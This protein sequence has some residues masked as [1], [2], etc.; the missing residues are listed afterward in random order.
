[1][2]FAVDRN[3]P[4]L[5]LIETWL[6][7]ENNSITA[8]IKSYGY[9]II[10]KT[11]NCNKTGKMRGG[12][13]AIIFKKCLNLR[14]V[15]LSDIGSAETVSA[16]LKTSSGATLFCCC[17][18]R[19][20]HLSSIFFQEFDE[21]LSD[22]FL[23]FQNVIL[24]GDINIHLDD[25]YNSNA[26]KF[27]ELLS[28][29]GL[30]QIVDRPTHKSG[31]TLDIV[32]TTFKV[33]DTDTVVVEPAVT[34]L[35]PGCDHYPISFSLKKCF[36]MYSHNTKKDIIFRNIK[37]IDSKQFQTDLH[38]FTKL[39]HYPH[40]QLPLV[41]V[42]FCEAISSFNM[43]CTKLLDKHAPI[44]NKTI[45][46][47][48]ASPWFD[49]E[50]KDLR[51]LRRHAEKKW[52]NS[53][54]NEIRE[55]NRIRYMDLRERCNI[56]ALT[57][58]KQYFQEQFENL[59]YSPKSLFAFV[60]KFIDKEKILTLPPN[61]SLQQTAE[62]FNK[63]FQDKIDEIQ[64]N[65]KE[66]DL[67]KFSGDT[68][69]GKF[70]SEFHPTTIEEVTEVM[71]EC[72][73]KTS[74]ADSLPASLINDNINVLIPYF[75]YLVNLSLAT[76]NI[77]GI[78]L[79]HVTP[80]IK[81]HNSDTS[82]LKNYRPISNLS[83]IG[84]LVERIVLRRL[85]EHL[86]ANN[87][88][89]PNQSGYKQFHSTETLLIKIVDDLLIAFDER[90][91]TVVMLLDLSAAFDTVNHGKLLNILHFEIGITGMA[92]N[93]FR[94]FITGRSQRIKIGAA[95]SE[96]ITIKFGVPQGS[97][98][99]PVLFNLYIRSLYNT[100]KS[101]KFAIQGYADD[102]QIYQSFDAIHQYSLL[103][104]EISG[105]FNE[106]RQWMAAHFLQLNPDKTEIIV[107]GTPKVLSELSIHGTYLNDN[108]CVR[109]SPIV[110]NLG[111]RLDNSL[112]LI[113]QVNHVKSTCYN[114][115]RTIAKMKAFLN[116][117]QLT[118]LI[119]ATIS[120]SLDYCNALYFGCN[121]SIIKELQNIQNRACKLIFGLKRRDSVTPYLKSL[122]W[123]K[124]KYRIEFKILYLVH[125]CIHRKAPSYL[126]DTLCHSNASSSRALSLHVPAIV[127][128]RAFSS[129]GPILW[130]ALPTEIR[131]IESNE[132]FKK[133][134]KTHLFRKCYLC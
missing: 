45:T 29:F 104:N 81:D 67:S 133:S 117:T 77:D 112:S 73:L 113:K 10:H 76:G 17:I 66:D 30:S 119:Q 110:K 13:V 70:L 132:L 32:A 51:I 15:Y 58:K 126:I 127:S 120:S 86:T 12:G 62:E 4:I 36:S 85:N 40:P 89:I 60:D 115:L 106:I 41:N 92:L 16:K 1:M 121:N 59:N 125:K 72:D 97:V 71:K 25:P 99:G 80:L 53:K 103:V 79:A 8:T 102:H 14:Q 7:D 107:F 94:S 54:T 49:G 43:N 129:A 65:F 122:H 130:N 82:V 34:Q 50:Y 19:T 134:L 111:F 33:I 23:K 24:C 42:S 68:F 63:Y 83:F 27:C 31:H 35:F 105:C 101:L 96:I 2:S 98:L 56:L 87:L 108:T 78:K 90:K 116:K 57:K 93:W 88:N 37:S 47:R 21:L 44:L 95:E 109:F 123:L 124:I 5:F 118:M 52:L 100:V 55:D 11:R 6:T 38:Q 9:N 22:I 128:H 75:C 20:D 69:N 28:S 64:K 39:P 84:K 26:K 61:D 3:I 91:A 74:T 48:P 46:D 114:K 131:T 18:Y